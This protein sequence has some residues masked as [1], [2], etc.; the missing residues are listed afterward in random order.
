M[1]NPKWE[2]GPVKL[3]GGCDAVIHRFCEKRR[4]YI[5]EW[6][7]MFTWRRYAAEWNMTGQHTVSGMGD[8]LL[9]L[10]PPPM[11]I[12]PFKAIKR[13]GCNE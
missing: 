11:N 10:A 3:A 5:G 4:K 12:E 9:D 1:T 2:I 6:E 8:P 7:G 13:R